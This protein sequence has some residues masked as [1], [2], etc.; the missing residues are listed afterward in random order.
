VTN[1]HSLIAYMATLLAILALA[2]IAA[3]HGQLDSTVF[4]TAIAGLIGIAGT[5]RPR[6][7]QGEGN[8]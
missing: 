7:Q 3:T 4:S 1:R 8:A 2:I 6:Q 5:F